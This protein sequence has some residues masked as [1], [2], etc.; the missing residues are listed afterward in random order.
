MRFHYIQLQKWQRSIPMSC[1]LVLSHFLIPTEITEFRLL[2][3]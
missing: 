1:F 3:L 2:Y